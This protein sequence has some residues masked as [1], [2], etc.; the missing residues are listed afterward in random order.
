[1][2]TPE[3]LVCRRTR[4]CVKILKAVACKGYGRTV[5]IPNPCLEACTKR[6]WLWQ[7]VETMQSRFSRLEENLWYK[8]GV[9]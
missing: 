4:E 8:V 5:L 1:M 9:T 3:A 7:L 2:K 6:V